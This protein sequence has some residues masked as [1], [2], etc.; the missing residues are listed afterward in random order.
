M[1]PPSK[2][3]AP[4]KDA[5]QPKGV[6]QR[7][8]KPPRKVVPQLKR[9][10]LPRGVIDFEDGVA[11]DAASRERLVEGVAPSRRRSAPEEKAEL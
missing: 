7:K 1:P 3:A 10:D 9:K 4:R 6:T 5:A 8:D 2:D 11:V